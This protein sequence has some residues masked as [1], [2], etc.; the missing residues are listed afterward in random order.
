MENILLTIGILYWLNII[1]ASEWVIPSGR[2]AVV[3]YYQ[4]AGNSQV[5]A[6]Q[7]IQHGFI[8]PTTGEYIKAQQGINV[9]KELWVDPEIPEVVLASITPPTLSEKLLH[10]LKIYQENTIRKIYAKSKITVE[11]REISS[12]S[13]TLA[14]HSIDWSKVSLGQYSD[15][16]CHR[17]RVNKCMNKYHSTHDQIWMGTSRGAP[18]GFI[19]AALAHKE[20]PHSLDSLK[21]VI[22]ESCYGSVDNTVDL[23]FTS[24]LKR[25]AI[26]LCFTAFTDYKKKGINA[27]DVVNDFPSHIPLA[28][29]TS[30]DDK[31]VPLEEVQRL[32][33][34]IVETG[35][36]NI[37][38]LILEHA[39]HGNYTSDPD[40]APRYQAFLH[41]LFEK[42]NL[43]Y[44]KAYAQEGKD[45]LKIAEETARNNI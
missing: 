3:I 36:K 31:N 12:S 20:N 5:E 22:A 15:I 25:K 27:F 10:P 26:E 34:R 29:I 24:E 6:S 17:N 8:S 43:P 33:K 23:L 13:S 11:R 42:Y 40:D 35:K 21:L 16:Q 2:D 44:I 41:A 18:V 45:L 39:Q 7:Y 19:S 28:L 30:K 1:N 37:Y 32:A 9:I 4:G 14:A 38:L